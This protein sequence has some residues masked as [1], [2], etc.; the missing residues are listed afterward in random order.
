MLS[1]LGET[2]VTD[3]HVH[4]AGLTPATTYH[5]KT[6]SVDAAGNLAV[7]PEYTFT[8]LEKE[9]PLVP[10]P[11]PPAPAPPPEVAEPINWPLVGGIIARVIVVGLLIFFLV[12]RRAS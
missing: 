3:H 5:Y 2:L 7:S 11:A 6:M 10:E 12:R 9:K 4:L 8:T 1:P